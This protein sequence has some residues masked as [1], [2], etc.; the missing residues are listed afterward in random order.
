MIHR[1]DTWKVSHDWVNECGQRAEDAV[2]RKMILR[3]RRGTERRVWSTEGLERERTKRRGK[4][5]R[6]DVKSEKRHEKGKEGR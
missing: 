5:L 4:R 3:L 1:G 6:M 2:K